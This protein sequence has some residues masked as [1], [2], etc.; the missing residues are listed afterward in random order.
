MIY[1]FEWTANRIVDRTWYNNIKK[2]RGIYKYI[3]PTF[4]VLSCLIYV[5]SHHLPCS[6]ITTEELLNALCCF[7]LI[8]YLIFKPRYSSLFLDFLFLRLRPLLFCI[9]WIFS[10]SRFGSF[11]LNRLFNRIYTE[12]I[13][14]LYRIWYIHNLFQWFLNSKCWFKINSRNANRTLSFYVIF[15]S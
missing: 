14:S 10:L 8:S 2:K 4:P 5:F 15:F 12:Y 9:Y 3:F 6:I 7:I 11:P 13:P 1:L